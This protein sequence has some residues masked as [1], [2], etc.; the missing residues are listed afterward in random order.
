MLPVEG[1]ILPLVAPP[2]P[3]PLHAGLTVPKGEAM[4]VG[5][6]SAIVEE[7][8]HMAACSAGGSVPPA[9]IKR[10]TSSVEEGRT[11]A[12]G[13]KHRYMSTTTSAGHSSGTLHRR[14]ERG[15]GA[16]RGKQPEHIAAL[17]PA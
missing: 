8:G 13:L 4:E 16:V 5:G 2:G 14:R 3:T 15:Q 6:S 12:S 1:A 10:S 11:E 17:P 9:S 7:V